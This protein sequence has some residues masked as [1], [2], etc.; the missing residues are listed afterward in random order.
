MSKEKFLSC[1][2]SHMKTKAL[3]VG[4]VLIL[5]KSENSSL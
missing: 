4:V 5:S 1:E 3:S 2:S